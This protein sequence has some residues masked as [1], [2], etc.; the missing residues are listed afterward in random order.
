M[1]P[2]VLPFLPLL[3][4]QQAPPPGKQVAHPEPA[5]PPTIQPDQQGLQ[6]LQGH[7]LI[8]GKI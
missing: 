1:I 4:L 3:Q 7:P 8:P 6:H 5:G 2:E